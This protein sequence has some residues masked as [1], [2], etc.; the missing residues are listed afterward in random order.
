[1]LFSS[2]AWAAADVVLADLP[3]SDASSPSLTPDGSNSNRGTAN[4]DYDS[5]INGAKF[6]NVWGENNS[7]GFKVATITDQDVTTYGQWT[8]EFDWAGYS[9]CNKKAGQ[10]KLMDSNGNTFF[11]IDDAANWG[12]TFSLS[13]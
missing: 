11:S 12:N 1:L 10:T 4:Y 7:N 8:L 5:P 3:F 13:I 6:L 2:G 9:G